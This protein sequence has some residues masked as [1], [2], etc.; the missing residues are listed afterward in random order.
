MFYIKPS[1][2]CNLTYCK[3][4]PCF[5]ASKKKRQILFSYFEFMYHHFHLASAIPFQYQKLYTKSRFVSTMH[6]AQCIPPPSP[7]LHPSTLL[8]PPTPW[9]KVLMKMCMITWC[10]IIIISSYLVV[11]VL[12]P[13]NFELALQVFMMVSFA[14]LTII[15]VFPWFLIAL[16]PIGVVFFLI[17][18][19]YRKGVHD[20]KRI[21]NV[22]R[23]PWFSHIS[24]TTLGLSTIHAYDKTDEFVIK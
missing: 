10:D 16:L 3:I 2:C 12:L 7:H 15:I 24:S 22:T 1:I 17:L 11:D 5:S 20:L 4:H 9:V 14:L 6:K 18:R 13:I 19:F 23:S 8:H 21:E